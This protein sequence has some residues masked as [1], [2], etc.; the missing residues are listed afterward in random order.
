MSDPL[1]SVKTGQLN[2][3]LDQAGYKNDHHRN[4]PE[5]LKCRNGHVTR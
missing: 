3:A 4:V 2:W 5:I 1:G